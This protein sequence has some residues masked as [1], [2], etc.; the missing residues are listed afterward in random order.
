M[1]EIWKDIKDYEGLYQISN[2]GR[3][4]RLA[5]T[6]KICPKGTEQYDVHFKEHLKS[7]FI[8]NRGYQTVTL[9]KNSKLKSHHIHRLVAEAFLDNPKN[10]PQVN[11]K[12]ENKLNNKVENLEWCTPSYNNNYGERNNKMAAKLSK[13]VICIE[14]GITYSGIHEAARQTGMDYRNIHACC[15]GRYK[16]TGG[17]HWEYV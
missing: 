16:T 14:T 7:T 12:D 8:M 4:K 3:V 17:Y 6:R 10:L 2:L 11:H 9:C 5:Y 13:P 15:S 1:I